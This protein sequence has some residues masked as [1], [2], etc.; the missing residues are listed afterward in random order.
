MKG[1][2]KE[3]KKSIFTKYF[4]KLHKKLVWTKKQVLLMLDIS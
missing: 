4:Q 3:I 1:A 2:T